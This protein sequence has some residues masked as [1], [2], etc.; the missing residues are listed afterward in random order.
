MIGRSTLDMVGQYQTWQVN[1]RHG[2]QKMTWQVHEKFR[3]NMAVKN[4]STWWVNISLGRL[5]SVL[6][7]QH[8][9]AVL[10]KQF[11]NVHCLK[12][13]SQALY[14]VFIIYSEN[15]S[16]HWRSTGTQTQSIDRSILFSVG[17]H[18]SRQGNI[19][20]GRPALVL[21]GQ[22]VSINP[23]GS[24]SSSCFLLAP[25]VRQTSESFGF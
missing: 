15:K 21:V 16:P 13:I 25:L 22:L 5:T 18:K 6:V 8:S 20:L 11:E 9:A 23:A 17:Q 2:R 12:Q 3:P 7:Y 24:A 19:S 4:H 10:T 1:I 14:I